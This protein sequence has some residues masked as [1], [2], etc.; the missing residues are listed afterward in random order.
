MFMA[1]LLSRQTLVGTPPSLPAIR[2]RRRYP[3]RLSHL[4]ESAAFPLP[5]PAVLVFDRRSRM[6]TKSGHLPCKGLQTLNG[7]KAALPH[8][9]QQIPA[10]RV[11]RRQLRVT[12]EQPIR[13]LTAMV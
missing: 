2:S 13:H 7:T 9:H 1:R 6:F 3:I 8:L 11:A 4:R 10:L 12:A 5:R